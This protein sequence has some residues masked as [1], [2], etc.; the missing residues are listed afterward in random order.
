M[1]PDRNLRFGV[2]ALQ[3]GMIDATRFVTACSAWAARGDVA[4]PDLLLESGW[5]DA[6]GRSAVDEYVKKNAV[7]LK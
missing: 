5:I 7:P 2:Q 1:D 6:A 3:M 4:L